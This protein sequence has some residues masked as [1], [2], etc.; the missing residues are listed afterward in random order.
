MGRGKGS[1]EEICPKAYQALLKN[2]LFFYCLCFS[3][4]L[5][6]LSLALVPFFLLRLLEFLT[7]WRPQKLSTQGS[8]SGGVRVPKGRARV[9]V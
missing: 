3:L 2:G 6:S 5:F 9:R 4:S 7:P 1:T 8:Q